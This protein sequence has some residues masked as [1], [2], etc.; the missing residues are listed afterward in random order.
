MGVFTA[1]DLKYFPLD[2]AKKHLTITGYKT[3]RELNEIP[4]L[5]V[6][7]SSNRDN[8][9]PSKSFAKGVTDISELETALNEYCTLAIERM[10]REESSCRVICVFLGTA[11]DFTGIHPERQ[12]FNYATALLDTPTNYLPTI[13]AAATQLLHKIYRP[14]FAYRKVQISL[15]DLHPASSPQ[16]S[17]IFTQQDILKEK[18]TA[19][20]DV[21]SNINE[22]Y[23]RGCLHLGIRNQTKKTG[24]LMNREFLSP[25]YTTR[26]LEMPIILD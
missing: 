18:N 7:Q 14:E 22:K 5:D 4:A 9:S 21:F 8:I 1:L 25:S 12:Y 23:G 20:M 24:W 26:L 6:Q 17:L 10:H 19:I 11:R 16:Q 15:L 2:K 13:S 3:V